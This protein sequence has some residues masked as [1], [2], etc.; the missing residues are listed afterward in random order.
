MV[1][2]LHSQCICSRLPPAHP[3][4]TFFTHADNAVMIILSRSHCTFYSSPVSYQSCHVQDDTIGRTIMVN[5]HMGWYPSPSDPPHLFPIYS[6]DL[7]YRLIVIGILLDTDRPATPRLRVSYRWRVGGVRSHTQNSYFKLSSST[8]KNALCPRVRYDI[9]DRSGMTS[10]LLSLISSSST[11][12]VR[13][14]DTHS[15]SRF[16]SHVF[17]G[18]PCASRVSS[19]KNHDPPIIRLSRTKT[20]T[21]DGGCNTN[22][23]DERHAALKIALL[24]HTYS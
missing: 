7:R 4:W 9:P 16:H 13:I 6:R 19:K 2:Y 22:C 24:A 10:S 12:F 18:G 14:R 15:Y 20:I 3:L 5:H 21:S 17:I 1:W 8:T 23:D 11:W